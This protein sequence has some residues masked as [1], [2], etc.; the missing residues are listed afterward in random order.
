L[1]LFRNDPAATAESKSWAS[2]YA[3]FISS[4]DEPFE[5]VVDV[6]YPLINDVSRVEL[7]QDGYIGE[8][9]TVVGVLAASIYFREF[10]R[11]ILQPGSD[12]MIVVFENECQESFT[13]QVNGPETIFL[14]IYD[15]HE[16]RY[17]D[18]VVTR[19][20]RDLIGLSN[21]DTTYSGI[22]L[23]TE[24]CPYTVHIYPSSEMETLYTTNKA[25]VFTIVT[26]F[27]FLVLGLVFA[28]YDFKVERRQKRV[29]SSAI[30]SS[31]IVSSLFPSSVQDQLYHT[32]ETVQINPLSTHQGENKTKSTMVAASPIA[33]LYPE[34]TVMFADIKGFTAWTGPREPAQVFHLL[35]TIYGR[36]DS[37]AKTL[38]VFKVE[39]IGDTYVAV[40]GLPTPRK[41]HAVIMARF[42]KRCIDAMKELTKELEEV[43]GSVRLFFACISLYGRIYIYL[44]L[45]IKFNRQGTADLSIRVGLNSGPTTAGVLRGEKARF[46]LF[47]D[48]SVAYIFSSL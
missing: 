37:I 38:G 43:L 2:Y 8:N 23:D 12:G 41:H 6:M 10:I 27:S 39:T 32:Q 26:V 22:P 28:L 7:Y 35:E 36:F 11:N 16:T 42:A 5:P 14:G 3:D 31:E 21:H 24:Y 1:L 13:Y 40:V 46:Q 9:S 30:R 18:L 17:D 20:F 34:T 29:L 19:G 47:G 25:L 48:V 45:D 4:D 15:K 44:T 33:K